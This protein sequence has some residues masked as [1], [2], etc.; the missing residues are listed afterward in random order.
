MRKRFRRCWVIFLLVTLL[1]ACGS[2]DGKGDKPNSLPFKD[3]FTEQGS[4]HTTSDP[5]V[6]IAYRDGGLSIQ[7]KV[8]DRVAWT[9]SGRQFEDLAVDVDATQV[10]GPDDNSYGLIARYQDDK[11]FY[12]FE[13][14][15]DG[16]YAIH[17]RDGQEWIPLVN[18]TES[19]AINRGQASNHLRVECR[20]TSLS[21]YVNG[22][23]L[24]Q[25]DDERYSRGDVGLVAATLYS[26]TGTHILFENFE[27]SELEE[28]PK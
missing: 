16:Y 20:G 19:R 24:H 27:V 23:L 14:S 9:V 11:H 22:Q 8:L 1:T 5:E 28:E 3:D 17:A 18:W 21:F 2:Q 13:I 6:E 7:V 12:R 10:D 4:W 26:Q 25:V 15:G